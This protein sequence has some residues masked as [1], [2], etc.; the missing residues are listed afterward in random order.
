M[1]KSQ[2]TTFAKLQRERDRQAKQ[3]EKR[4][5]K[6]ARRAGEELPTRDDEQDEAPTGLPFNIG[7]YPDEIA[8]G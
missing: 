4:E 3:A 1:A 2:R 8:Q 6:R 7:R 5:R